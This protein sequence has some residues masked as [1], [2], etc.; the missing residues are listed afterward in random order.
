MGDGLKLVARLPPWAIFWD[1]PCL[2]GFVRRNSAPAGP[3][4]HE[5]NIVLSKGVNACKPLSTIPGT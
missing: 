1:W 4:L 3:L 5:E 2:L